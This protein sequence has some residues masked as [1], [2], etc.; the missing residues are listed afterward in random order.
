MMDP[1]IMRMLCQ[2]DL[3]LQDIYPPIPQKLQMASKEQKPP[4]TYTEKKIAKK[5]KEI[6][7]LE[8]QIVRD[9]ILAWNKPMTSTPST[10]SPKALAIKAIIEKSD[11]GCKKASVA[12]LFSAMLDENI[13]VAE[14]VKDPQGQVVVVLSNEN[15]SDYPTNVP[16]ITERLAGGWHVITIDKTSRIHGSSAMFRTQEMAHCWRYATQEEVKEFAKNASADSLKF[17]GLYILNRNEP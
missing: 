9:R 7:A 11:F 2:G 16:M 17:L 15:S 3:S 8:N 5:K 6:E 10:L 12:K 4:T 14:E 1:G 13:T